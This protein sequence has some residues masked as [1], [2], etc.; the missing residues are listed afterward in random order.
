MLSMGSIGRSLVNRGLPFDTLLCTR[1]PRGR[2]C[3]WCVVYPGVVV[4]PGMVRPRGATRGTGPGTSLP[5]PKTQI[6]EKQGEPGKI[7][8]F[9]E[10]SEKSRISVFSLI[11]SEFLRKVK[12]FS[13]F[14][15]FSEFLRKVKEWSRHSQ[16]V[17]PAQSKSGPGTVITRAQS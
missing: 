14:S 5:G 10:I 9:R 12:N 4:V 3:A 1:R 2:H 16:R 7:S 17:V 8:N 11:F 13:I 6:W 15:N